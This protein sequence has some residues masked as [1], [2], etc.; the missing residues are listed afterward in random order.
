MNFTWVTDLTSKKIEPSKI[1]FTEL[2]AKGD[3]Q[4]EDEDR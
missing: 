2:W 1:C 4:Q 3:I